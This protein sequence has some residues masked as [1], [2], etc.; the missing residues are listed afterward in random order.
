MFKTIISKK[1]SV[2]LLNFNQLSNFRD[3]KTNLF[4]NSI[5]FF[6]RREVNKNVYISNMLR[7]IT[8]KNESS[9]IMSKSKV[10]IQQELKKKYDISP[11]LQNFLSST[12]SNKAFNLENMD[13]KGFYVEILDSLQK[14]NIE[15]NALDT[16]LK[17]IETK[18]S[19]EYQINNLAFKLLLLIE[20]ILNN[21][22]SI[23]NYKNKFSDA[24]INTGFDHLI[25]IYREN[26]HQLN[27]KKEDLLM[28]NFIFFMTINTGEISDLFRTLSIKSQKFNDNLEKILSQS[29]K[30]KEDRSENTLNYNNFLDH[31]SNYKLAPSEMTND[32]SFKYRD[33]N[34]KT[35]LYN[36]MIYHKQNIH[37]IKY[38]LN[39][40]NQLKNGD[41]VGDLNE[42]E[43]VLSMFLLRDVK[44]ILSE[45]V[46][47]INHEMRKFN[48]LFEELSSSLT[49]LKLVDYNKIT[50]NNLENIYNPLFSGEKSIQKQYLRAANV[51][52]NESAQ[53]LLD[54]YLKQQSKLKSYT[55]K[56]LFNMNLLMNNNNFPI[57]KNFF[58]IHVEIINQNDFDYKGFLN[59]YKKPFTLSKQEKII[60]DEIK[61]SLSSILKFSSTVYTNLEKP[62]KVNVSKGVSLKSGDSASKQNIKKSQT[63]QKEEH[64][65]NENN[66]KPSAAD[67]VK[68]ISNLDIKK[69]ETQA[70]NSSKTNI[71]KENLS[72]KNIN[73]KKSD[74]YKAYNKED[75]NKNEDQHFNLIKPETK[76]F[77]AE[78]EI[79]LENKTKD[80][81]KKAKFSP[82]FE[83]FNELNN[84]EE[85]K[86]FKP[87]VVTKVI[88]ENIEQEDET[89][90]ND[91]TT[92]V[93][94]TFIQ[95]TTNES[96]SNEDIIV[97]HK[98]TEEKNTTVKTEVKSK[99]NE[100][101]NKTQENETKESSSP[102]ENETKESS[103]PIE[104]ATKDVSSPIENE[105][106]ESSS[107]IENETKESSS[108]IEN[109]TKDV[110]S[111][112]ENETKESSSPIENAT[113]ESSSP[114][115]N[116][117]KEN[118]KIS[119]ETTKSN[120][121]DS[122][123][124]IK[125]ENFMS[126]EEKF[127]KQKMKK[128]YYNDNKNYHSLTTRAIKNFSSNVLQEEEYLDDNKNFNFSDK[129]N[130]SSNKEKIRAD[131]QNKLKSTPN[132]SSNKL[133]IDESSKK[134]TQKLDSNKDRIAPIKFLKIEANKIQIT[135]A[136]ISF[137][138]EKKVRDA[139]EDQSILKFLE[140]EDEL[141]K[142]N[143]DLSNNFEIV[144]EANNEMNDISIN[145][146]MDFYQKNKKEKNIARS[147]EIH[148][149]QL[150]RY[151]FY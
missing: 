13:F 136:K 150:V 19:S 142:D 33:I 145:Y 76:A 88:E 28:N 17:I 67:K 3:N 92:T 112:I 131:S 98:I 16:W 120:I 56:D 111:P 130:T 110:S 73:E 108:P 21:S 144:V 122:N 149:I 91:N 129:N 132:F 62:Q 68:S 58:N 119:D 63:F 40:S 44:D 79:R 69:S 72:S 104:N 80:L 71:S 121:S 7:F 87:I 93:E 102:I 51:L 124:D 66:N 46:I 115:E 133:N 96:V 1:K 10:E 55:V 15:I 151:N 85:E 60:F 54:L 65:I 103:S 25:N 89:K 2:V 8:E 134:N 45:D 53:K 117:T 59:I 146:W 139:E 99:N 125:K 75:K 141:I 148:L 83:K 82:I 77:D 30:I 26:F 94:K 78:E 143:A 137:K 36:N 147:F 31:E 109:E 23:D 64:N 48:Q 74:I 22:N 37:K 5:K 27:N 118:N 138:N 42:I 105:T 39:S 114:I 4:I 101:L 70:E 9:I 49:D 14:E 128:F 123:S 29:I 47:K 38:L 11:I 81:N 32:Y 34:N 113:K 18:Y 100:M 140:K 86:V 52:G 24:F 116:E 57:A 90:K 97:E 95:L 126:M 6:A 106:K 43:K 135:S 12:K 50:I 127:K 84:K 35:A 107:P 41:L 61:D 20:Q